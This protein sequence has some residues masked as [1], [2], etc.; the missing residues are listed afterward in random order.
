MSESR[1]ILDNNP[2]MYENLFEK[3]FTTDYYEQEKRIEAL[4]EEDTDSWDIVVNGMPLGDEVDMSDSHLQIVLERMSWLSG[5]QITNLTERMFSKR[6]NGWVRY[7]D[8]EKEGEVGSFI[9][10][11]SSVAENNPEKVIGAMN[12]LTETEKMIAETGAFDNAIKEQL[13]GLLAEIDIKKHTKVA[14]IWEKLVD[15]YTQFLNGIEEDIKM[16]DPDSDI[17]IQLNY[18]IDAAIKL[19]QNMPAEASKAWNM[20]RNKLNNMPSQVK[21]AI[22]ERLEKMKNA[23]SKEGQEE[24][25]TPRAEGGFTPGD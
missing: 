16:E 23:Q 11:L 17:Y 1:T 22:N 18:E 21:E 2:F 6:W 12:V 9:T 15:D 8:T 4:K 14:G 25:I 10:R 19:I 3:K 13:F 5:D 24:G 20:L 7:A